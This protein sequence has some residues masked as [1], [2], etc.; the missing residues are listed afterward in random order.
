MAA[1][2]LN[3]PNAHAALEW[4]CQTYWYPLYCFARRKGYSPADA[5]N[6]IQDFLAKLLAK[7]QIALADRK[8][9]RFRT[10]L[11]SSLEHFRCND[12]ERKTAQKRGGG[13]EIISLDAQTAEQRYA[14]EPVDKLSPEQIYDRC[15][16][17]TLLDGTLK[18]LRAEFST[19]GRVDLFES[20]EPH[21]W[22]DDSA[23][24]HSQVATELGMSVGVV[25]M[26]LYRLRQ[27]YR[28]LLREEIAQ[29]VG[30][31][32]DVEEELR[33]LRQVLAG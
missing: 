13:R 27:R 6:L 18:R 32:E 23:T 31:A 25:K 10:F 8:R 15:W 16:A 26:T 12:Y 1:R 17:Q 28:D 24:P 20:L 11:Q 33:H 7:N 4:L 9:G 30:S 2:T 21:L 3:S 14:I 5:E 22:K 29:T 19:R